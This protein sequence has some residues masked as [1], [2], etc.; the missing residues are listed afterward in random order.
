MTYN[1]IVKQEKLI[2]YA[3]L[4]MEASKKNTYDFRMFRKLRPFFEEI[5]YGHKR[6]DA[7]ERDQDIF[8]RELGRLEGMVRDLKK[9]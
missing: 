5:Y 3:Y 2:N 4:Y 6:I 7:I 1:D 9:I 8:Q